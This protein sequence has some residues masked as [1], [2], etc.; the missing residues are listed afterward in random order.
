M[1]DSSDE[2][3]GHWWW[4]A[5]VQRLEPALVERLLKV[6]RQFR[7]RPGERRVDCV[8]SGEAITPTRMLC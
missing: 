7:G 5:A 2:V 1:T 6:A 3:F 4:H 8:L